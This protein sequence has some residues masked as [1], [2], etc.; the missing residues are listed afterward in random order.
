MMLCII[1][2]SNRKVDKANSI[3][4]RDLHDLVLG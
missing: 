1:A 2:W 3:E 4:E